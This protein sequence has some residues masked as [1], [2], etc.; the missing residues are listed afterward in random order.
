MAGHAERAQVLDLAQPA[1]PI[2]RHDVVRV[3]RVAFQAGARQPLGSCPRAARREAGR[4]ARQ[5]AA[6][7]LAPAAAALL[8]RPA[9]AGA[10]TCMYAQHAGA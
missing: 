6:A 7:A 2:D 3:P 9:H 1:A 10:Q 8:D 5:L 4:E